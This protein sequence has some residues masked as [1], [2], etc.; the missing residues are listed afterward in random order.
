MTDFKVNFNHGRQ[1][2][3]VYLEDVTPTTF[4]RRGGGRWGFW[5]GADER[6]ERSGLFGELHLVAERVR[7]DVVAHELFHVVADWLNGKAIVP[8]TEERAA[9]LMDEL[10]RNFWREYGKAVN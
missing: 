6:K 10:T 5:L 1:Y 8:Q 2:F 4:H 7:N 3:V 9:L